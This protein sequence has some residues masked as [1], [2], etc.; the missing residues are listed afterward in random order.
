MQLF[1]LEKEAL[2]QR[3]KSSENGLSSALAARRLREFGPNVLEQGAKKNYLLAYAR[4]YSQFFAI[5]LEVAALLSFVADH[6]DSKQGSD[7]LG[8]AIIGAVI[9][10]ATFTFWQEYRADKA[11]EELLKLIPVRVSL[12]RDG[13]VV[14]VEA[15]DLVPGDIMLLEEGDKVAADGIILEANSLYLNL[16]SLTGESAPVARS[17]Q[18]DTARRTLEAKNMVFAGTTVL[19]GSGIAVVSATGN[20]TE[21]GN[22]ASLT[23]NVRKTVTPMQREIIHITRIFTGIALLMGCVFFALGLFSGKGILMASIFALALIVANVPEGLL[24]TI[25]LSLSL[26]SQRMA[27]HNALVKNLD[28]VQTLGSATVI[29]TDK[30]GTLTRNEMST[31]LLWLAGGEE[32]SISGEGYREPGEFSFSRHNESSE[33]RL[34]GLLTAGIL[35]C[36][37]S[38][39]DERLRGDPTELAIVAAAGKRGIT[40]P[41]MT[42]VREFIFTSERKIMSTV[43]EDGGKIRIFAKGA[44]EVLLPR[45]TAFL[46]DDGREQPLS[47]SK[48][49]EALARAEAF[50]NQAF[51][52]LLIACGTEAREEALTLLGLVAIMDL[53][54]SE[55]YAAIATCKR[56][57]IRTMMITGDNPRTAA[58]IAQQIGMDFSRVV[59]GP[60]LEEMGD[61]HLEEILSKET[62]LFARMASSQKLRIATALQNN[63]EVVAMTGDGVNDAPALK[64]ADIGIAM[65]LSGTEVAKEAA[66]MVLLD[67]NFSSIVI[68]IEEG[69]NVYFNIKKFVTYVLASNAPE[70]VPY[71]L[72][73]FLK[74]PLPL[75]VIQILS[76]DLGT[77]ILPGVALGSERP[78]KNIMNRPPVGRNEKILDR[79]V[80]LRGYF[81]LGVIEAT[82]AMAAFLSFLLLHGWQYGTVD[83]ADPL[84]HRQAMTMTLLGAVSC[85]LLNAWT[86]R[87]WE[88]SAF[89]LG[90]FSNRLLLWAMAVEL[91]WVWAILNVPEVQRVF[92]TASVPL[93]DLWILLPFPLLLFCAHE[94]YKWLRRRKKSRD[95]LPT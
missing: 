12:R 22:I 16:S 46:G 79:E 29:C 35:N 86:M 45:C 41:E 64:K 93:N 67:D 56:A 59:T 33:Q 17:L 82:A 51:R 20:A 58:A 94:F 28:S 89:N 90:F 81:F 15:E 48:R 85:Q 76:I 53:P 34:T 66:D 36:R 73:F 40:A 19:S 2:L 95:L 30:T 68:A 7:V 60:E 32:I 50:E 37:A 6:Y 83:L 42:K 44:V 69:R 4:Q 11:M 10:N 27:R 74:I 43:F 88:F 52:V 9:V 70:I 3:L 1:T 65:G 92:N 61:E 31:K 25:S 54:R 62:V 78:E 5:L 49:R 72:Q 71:I 57:G 80:F 26:A 75:S 55:V 21:F 8:Y 24:P 84:L 23:K 63:G 47:E 87:S 18:P 91:V 38:I 77:D 13:D 14:Q 39:D